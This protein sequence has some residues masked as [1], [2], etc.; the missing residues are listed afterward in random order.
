MGNCLPCAFFARNQRIVDFSDVLIAFWDGKS[1]GTKDVFNRA[2]KRW[3]DLARVWCIMP[4]SYSWWA[5]AIQGT[6]QQYV[7]YGLPE[8]KML[9]D[10]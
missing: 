9:S 4:S 7:D 10:A 1:R 8:R 5:P 2:R 3:P 6:L